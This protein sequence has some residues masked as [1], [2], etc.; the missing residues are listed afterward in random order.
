MMMM[1][2]AELFLVYACQQGILSYSALLRCSYACRRWRDAALNV[3][4]MLP[5]GH[6]P[7]KKKGRKWLLDAV[8]KGRGWEVS[9]L[10]SMP[11]VVEKG[12][13]D[14]HVSPQS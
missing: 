4:P 5:A 14:P 6:L 11:F 2:D 8:K 1:H 7:R 12:R 9:F 10:L 3:L 13:P